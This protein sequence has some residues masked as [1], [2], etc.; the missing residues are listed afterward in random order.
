MYLLALDIKELFLFTFYEC[1]LFNDP[2]A[3]P[4]IL[5]G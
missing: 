3:N 1:S 5:I 2:R 4:G